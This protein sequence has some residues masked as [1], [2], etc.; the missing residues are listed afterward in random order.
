[1]TRVLAESD[2]ERCRP[3]LVSQPA[4]TVSSLAYVAAGADL[5]RR[6]ERDRAFGWAVV[7]VGIGSVAYHGPGGRAGRWLHDATLLSMLGLLV[8]SDLTVHDG[9][10]LPGAVV[11]AVVTAAAVA[12]HPATSEVAQLTVGTAAAGAEA[13]RIIRGGGRREPAV[14]GPLLLTGLAMQV[15]G[16]TGRP[17]CRP[18]SPAQAHAAWHVLSAAALWSR[19]RF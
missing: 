6:E 7:A 5:L 11:G 2:C 9:R 16:R 3:G 12:A 15:L 10:R 18:D 8:A 17:L 14:S 1:M 4:N 13:R 19:N